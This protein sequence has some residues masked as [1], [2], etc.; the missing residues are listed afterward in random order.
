M[1]EINMRDEGKKHERKQKV[2]AAVDY[3]PLAASKGLINEEM[4]MWMRV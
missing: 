4:G 1:S 3:L 2:L